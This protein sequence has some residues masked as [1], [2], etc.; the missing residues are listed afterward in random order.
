V[1]RKWFDALPGPLAVRLVLAF[2]VVAVLLA[3]LA[4]VFERAGDL[5]DNGGVISS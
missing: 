5:L 2:V 3:L 1:I 4:V